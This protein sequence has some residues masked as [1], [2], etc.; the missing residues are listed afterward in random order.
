MLAPP[1]PPMIVP[2]L[3]N[4]LIVPKLAIPAPPDRAAKEPVPPLPPPIVPPLASV[5]I[6]TGIHDP[7]AARA[8]GKTHAAGI[9]R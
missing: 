3:V 5:V 1:F 7:R 9:R 2:L 4:V 6:G 8:P